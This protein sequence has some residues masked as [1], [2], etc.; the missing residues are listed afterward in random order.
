MPLSLFGQ[1]DPPE[2]RYE[3]FVQIEQQ[4]ED[5][6]GTAISPE[7]QHRFFTWK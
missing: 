2:N 4:N 1:I 7:S 5:G 3:W 6:T